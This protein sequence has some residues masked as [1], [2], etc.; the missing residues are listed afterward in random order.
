MH[1]KTWAWLAGD[2]RL[3]AIVVISFRKIFAS[4]LILI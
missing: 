1:K 4:Y 2:V 3:G